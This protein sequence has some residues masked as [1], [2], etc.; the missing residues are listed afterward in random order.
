MLRSFPDLVAGIKL[1]PVDDYGRRL[2]T[3]MD[4]IAPEG[5]DDPQ[6][7]L[8]S[9]GI[10]NSA[11]F[12]HVFLAREM[13]VPLVEGADLV[14]EDD[15]VW[16]RT[17]GGLQPGAHH[18]PP[19]RRRLPR[20][21]RVPPG[22][23]A[24]RPR[25]DRRL[26][27]RQRQP[28]Q[29]RRHRRRRRQGRLRLHAAHHPLLPRR[30]PGAAQR[31]DLHLRRAGRPRL[32][33]RPTAPSSS[34]S[35]SARAAATA[36]PSARAPAPR[37]SSTTARAALL[38][39]PAN[40]ISQPM[41]GLSVAPTLTEQRPAAPPPR[42]APVRRH[43]PRHLGVA[44]RPVPR[45]AEGGQPDR[46]LLPGR[47]LQGHLGAAGRRMRHAMSDSARAADPRRRGPV[48][49]GPLSRAGRK[50][51]P[52]D[53]RHPDLRE[54]RPRSRLLVGA[55]RDQC[56]RPPSWTAARSTAPPSR[57]STCS[58]AT[59]RNSIPAALEFARTNA[60]TLR[61]LI[62]TEMWMQLNVFHRAVMAITPD[63]L[64]GD[65]LSRLCRRIKEGVQAHTGITEGTFVRDQGWHFYM[66]GRLIERADQITRLL[67]IKYHCCCQ[68]RRRGA[69]RGGTDPVECRAAGGRRLPRLPPCRRR[70]GSSLGTW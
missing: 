57:A 5:V 31:R 32:H 36:S 54:P 27:P 53:R 2:R 13:G 49:D 64:E 16:M 70:P 47:R 35:P 6:V 38:A 4:E 33:A 1:R 55:D 29:R 30:G 20:P 51:R 37:A 61:P 65:A 43:R 19:D 8:L 48:L 62:S 34:S 68:R 60:R 18:L 21:H 26:A 69:P 9:P 39:D 17:T 42:P 63:D 25:A 67:D 66:L 15:R 46:Q 41:I 59:T 24:R 28:R 7:V 52:P 23:H 14:V 12:E 58:S 10:Y 44:R 40:W 45:R 22:Q 56:R 50:P 11:Y 3:A